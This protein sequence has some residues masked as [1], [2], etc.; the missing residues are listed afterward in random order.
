M[1]SLPFRCQ[2]GLR[3]PSLFCDVQPLHFEVALHLPKSLKTAWEHRGALPRG[4]PQGCLSEPGRVHKK[5]TAQSPDFTGIH[6]C[7]Y[8]RSFS[9]A[10]F[11]PDAMRHLVFVAFERKS[12]LVCFDVHRDI[13]MVG[14]CKA[15]K[16]HSLRRQQAPQSSW[17]VF[18]TPGSLERPSRLLA[19]VK[20]PNEV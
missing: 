5:V 8:S 15:N 2:C 7:S 3:Q 14:E 17:R 13:E 6:Q 11:K 9:V 16:G 19:R 18:E 12:L 1:V 10:G 4:R 20:S